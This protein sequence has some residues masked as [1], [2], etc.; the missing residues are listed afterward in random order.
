MKGGLPTPV[1]RIEK[2][3]DYTVMAN[4]HLKNRKLSLKAKGLL[5]VMLSLP[6]TW[7]YTLRGLACISLESVDAIREAVRELEKAGY[8]VRSRARNSQGQ[9][10]QM[11]YTIY[12]LP[13]LPTEENP[14]L[15]KPMQAEPTQDDAVQEE[16]VQENPLQLSTQ[17]S[18]TYPEIIE[19]SNK[20][21]ANPYPSNPHLISAWRETV[22]R[23]ISYDILIQDSRYDCKRLDEIVELMAETLATNRATICV[24]GDDYPA[25]EVRDRLLQINSLHIEYVFECLQRNTSYIRNIK[26]Y[27]LATLFN[28]PSTIDSYYSALVNHD[29]YRR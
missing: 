25:D 27:L 13:H 20:K 2:T 28:A 23:N 5:S 22:R 16:P 29:L 15:E 19:L 1:F 21:G 7:D 26:K 9:L 3:R 24:A 17:V 12:E 14:A 10:K 18:N 4:H 8:V 6:E 11:E